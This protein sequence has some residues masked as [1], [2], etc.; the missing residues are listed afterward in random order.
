M[1][2]D[3]YMNQYQVDEYDIHPQEDIISTKQVY[4]KLRSFIAFS[5]FVF[6]TLL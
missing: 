3:G 1:R 2:L 5:T 6:F 4:Q